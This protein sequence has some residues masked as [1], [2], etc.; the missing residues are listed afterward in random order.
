MAALPQQYVAPMP[1]CHVGHPPPEKTILTGS[2][3]YILI[4]PFG[5][6]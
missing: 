3:P 2:R 6:E 4:T 1:I 5:N